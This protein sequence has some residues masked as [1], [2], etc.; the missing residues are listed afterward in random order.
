MAETVA[1]QVMRFFER[2]G[3]EFAFGHPGGPIL[4]FYDAL[5]SREKPRLVTVRHEEAASFMADAY[6]KVTGTPG[7][8]MSTMGPGA[9]NMLIGVA[10][11][12][13]DF[14]PIIA[15]TGQLR[16]ANLGRGF[17]QET[18]HLSM[19][20]SVTK[21]SVQVKKVEDA[22][23]TVERAFKAAVSGR[24]G[25]VHIDFPRDI[26]ESRSAVEYDPSSYRWPV[27][28]EPQSELIREAADL[29]DEALGPV[30]LAGGGVVSSGAS[31]ALLSLAEAVAAPVATSFNGRTSVPENH[32]LSIG[33]VGEFTPKYS[34]RIVSEADLILAVGY[35]FT[36]VS[37][38]GFTIR[39][40]AKII[41]VDIEAS[42]LGKARSV[43]LPIVGDARLVLQALLMELRKR[44]VDAT[45]R[46]QWRDSVAK[47]KEEWLREYASY[48]SSDSVP[49]KPQRVMKEIRKVLREDAIITAGAGRSKMWAASV[50]PVYHPGTWIHSGGYAPMGYEVCAAIAAKL[51]RPEKQ[52][53]AVS[54]DASFQMVCQEIATA[55]ENNAPFVT[56]ILND[57]SL[58]VIR[59][60]Q[61]KNYGRAFGTEW[62]SDVNL[63]DVGRAFGA[64]GMRVEK[65]SDIASGLQEAL[66]SDRSYVLDIV[67]DVNEDPTFNI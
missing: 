55:A 19:Y 3:I 30:V 27:L 36:D 14:T 7:L 42:E 48:E 34:N 31:Q 37:T 65:P 11:A 10:T 13:S 52:V 49:I 26:S 20:K 39:P 17:Q 38:D 4:P 40:D 44:G 5:A 43:S 1:E 45:R 29:V 18:D 22:V 16:L 67:V 12:M 47:A 66:R 28:G 33:R 9:A 60:A 58:G 23:E 15:I 62:A 24:K 63:A 2:Q 61:I 25:P 56:C 41:Q 51:A 53:L 54:G 57:K 6:A 64:R 32:P 8:C 50:L 35:R 21:H 59:Y 46:R